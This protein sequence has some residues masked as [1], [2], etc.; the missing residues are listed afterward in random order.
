LNINDGVGSTNPETLQRK[1]VETGADLGI[2]LDGDGDRVIMA[3]GDGRI[4][5]GDALIYIIACSR[6]AAGKLEG[7]VVGTGMTNLGLEHALQRRGI[8]FERAKIG[9]RYILERLKAT[10]G[11]LGGEPSGH[12][13]CRDRTT[14]GDGVIAALQILA[15]IVTGGTSLEALLQDMEVYPQTLLNVRLPEKVDVL[16]SPAVQEAV[17]SAEGEMNGQGRVLLRPS[18]TEPVIRVMVEGRDKD[19]VDTLAR[20]LADSVRAGIES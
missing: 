11:V 10:G 13:I 18:G 16:S 9:D 1:V 14:T 20:R 2:A 12:I 19:Q 5:D 17:Q 6:H 15:E 7:P 8:A 3:D 4:V